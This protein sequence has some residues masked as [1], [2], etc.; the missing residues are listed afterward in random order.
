[1]TPFVL[2]YELIS[3]IVLNNVDYAAANNK[4]IAHFSAA[5]SLCDGFDNLLNEVVINRKF[6]FGFG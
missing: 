2:K 4:A 5:G 1:M 6:D 3:S